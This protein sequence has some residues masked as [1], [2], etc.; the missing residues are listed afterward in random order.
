MISSRQLLITLFTVLFISCIANV[1]YAQEKEELKTQD[2]LS[3]DLEDLL[4][5]SV[6]TVSKSAEKQS[7]A[8]GI[9]SVLTKDELKRFGGTSL[10]DILERVPG[11][12][13]ST[14]YMTDRSVLTIE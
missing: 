9:L 3:L 10:R 8:P 5:I 14:N 13:G 7:D 12:T 2:L 1:N 11:L 4:N 6:T